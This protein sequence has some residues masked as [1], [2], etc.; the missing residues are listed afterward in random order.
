MLHEYHSPRVF[1][2][3][4][5]GYRIAVYTGDQLNLGPHQFFSQVTLMLYAELRPP[6]EVE[7]YSAC[8]SQCMESE[9]NY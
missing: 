1:C 4:A 3:L 8:L 2:E 6:Y 7:G 9:G 5:L